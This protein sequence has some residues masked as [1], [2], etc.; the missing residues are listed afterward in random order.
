MESNTKSESPAARGLRS[1]LGATRQYVLYTSLQMSNW[2]AP[3][4]TEQMEM[5]QTRKAVES[6]ASEITGFL[7]GDWKVFKESVQGMELR[8]ME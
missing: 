1:Q 8:V 4:V 3:N 5:A 6:A 2:E 7:E